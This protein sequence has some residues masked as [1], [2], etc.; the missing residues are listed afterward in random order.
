MWKYVKIKPECKELIKL[1]TDEWILC[2]IVEK[3]FHI[4]PQK[5]AKI[6]WKLYPYSFF[7][8]KS[9]K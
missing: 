3:K 2:Q 5:F 8:K 1:K 7:Y 6:N 4:E 9:A